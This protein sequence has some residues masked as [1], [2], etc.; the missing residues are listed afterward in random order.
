MSLS[1]KD[2][3]FSETEVLWM[4]E[5]YRTKHFDPKIAKI[6]LKDKLPKQFNPKSIDNSFLIDGKNLT[7]FG[8]WH[9]DPNSTFFEIVEKT[10]LGIRD[11]IFERPGIEQI[12]S[13]QI[14]ARAGFEKEHVEIALSTLN[15]FGNFCGSAQQSEESSGI[16]SIGL[17]GDEAYDAYLA[18]ENIDKLLDET[19]KRY[20]RQTK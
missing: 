14:S 16:T 11:I 9:V 3:K 19:Y 2:H 18:F 1:Y 4:K 6:K 20:E 15:T 12:T 10:I 7:L 17:S 5:A 8:L 13:E